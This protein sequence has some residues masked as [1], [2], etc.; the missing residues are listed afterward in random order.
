MLGRSF[1]SVSGGSREDAPGYGVV[2]GKRCERETAGSARRVVTVVGLR[3]AGASCRCWASTR[4]P[5]PTP[6]TP[7]APAPAGN[8]RQR[9]CARAHRR[10]AAVPRRP[11]RHPPGPSGRRHA[12]AAHRRAAR[13]PRAAA[14]AC[15]LPVRRRAA[16]RARADRRAAAVP[17]RPRRHPPDPSGRRHPPAAHRRAARALRAA[18]EACGLPTARGRAGRYDGCDR[19]ARLRVADVEPPARQ[20]L[21]LAHGGAELVGRGGRGALAEHD[22]DRA[23][24]PEL[25]DRAGVEPLPDLGTVPAEVGD[26]RPRVRERVGRLH[27]Q[28]RRRRVGVA[29]V[30]ERL[31]L[32]PPP[33]RRVAHAPDASTGARRRASRCTP[34]RSARPCG[35]TACGSSSASRAASSIASCSSAAIAS[36]SVPPSSRTSAATSS[37][38]AR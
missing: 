20:L 36:D 37:R 24:V 13:R 11:G 7:G 9:P 33:G 10:A 12:P 23:V 35:R 31:L 18:A 3:R 22:G 1:R 6:A 16:G 28:H 21:H 32:A 17:R 34:A 8:R 15:G 4:S 30:R 19:A 38:W 29:E 2:G 14:E 5:P 25:V 26:D 27:P